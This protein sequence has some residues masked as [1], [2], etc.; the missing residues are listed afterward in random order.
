[1]LDEK[2][3][4]LL[5]FDQI[6]E[7]DYLEYI[8]EWEAREE[9]IVPSASKRMGRTFTDCLEAWKRDE[10]ELAYDRGFVPATLYF[11]Q[12]SSNRILGAIHYRHTLNDRLRENG[13]H[14]G[15]G[16]RFSERRKGLA[17]MMLKML[18]D[19]L[20]IKGVKEALI[21]CDASNIASSRTIEQCGGILMD[22]PVFEGV[23]TRRYQVTL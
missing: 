3:Y 19:A 11:L 13:G 21:T 6:A 23:L 14:I 17:S 8:S 4:V 18:L 10:S 1:M 9:G 15:Y 12:D 5:R 20:K 7:K 16:V 2:P 22:T